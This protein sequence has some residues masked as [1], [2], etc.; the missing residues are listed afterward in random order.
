MY[1]V[2]IL[3]FTTPSTPPDKGIRV[4]EDNNGWFHL[5]ET[6]KQEGIT[7]PFPSLQHVEIAVGEPL[8]LVNEIARDQFSGPFAANRVRWFE[9]ALARASDVFGSD[10]KARGW[11]DRPNGA[12][13]K[14]TPMSLLNT[15]EG[16]QRVL[17]VLGRI[18]YG[19]FE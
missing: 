17:D 3:T 10:V 11:L 5:V 14:V 4:V 15:D 16:V 8:T 1:F 19:I 18:E 13:G 12:L 9:Q 6:L 7:T 2:K